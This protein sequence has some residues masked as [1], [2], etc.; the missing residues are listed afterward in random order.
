MVEKE[1]PNLEI[2]NF[3]FITLSEK[4]TEEKAK[5]LSSILEKGDIILLDGELGAGKTTFAKGIAAGFGIKELLVS[6][7]F[8]IVREYNGEKKLI[9][10]DM[11]RINEQDFI[12]LGYL[13]T[14]GIDEVTVIEWGAKAADLLESYLLIKIKIIDEDNRRFEVSGFGLKSCRIAEEF[15]N[16]CFGY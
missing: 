10:I 9:H 12:E 5:C 14:I 4:Q 7:T 16:A 13:E 6:P 11:Y 1:E 2:Y 15:K 3:T 8:N